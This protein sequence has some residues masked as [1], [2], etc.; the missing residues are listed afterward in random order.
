MSSKLQ[1]APYPLFAFTIPGCQ[2]PG[3]KE[4]NGMAFNPQGGADVRSN[5]AQLMQKARSTHTI[6]SDHKP[7]IHIYIE[8][9]SY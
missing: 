5:L 6:W 3:C 9:R 8:L 1:P 4:Q 2:L 7:H